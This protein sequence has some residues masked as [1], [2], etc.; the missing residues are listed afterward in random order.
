MSLGDVLSARMRMAAGSESTPEIAQDLVTIFTMADERF[1]LG[2][3]ALLNSL[4]LTGHADLPVVVLDGGLTPNQRSAIERFAALVPPPPGARMGTA[5]AKAEVASLEPS[6]VVLVIDADCIVTGSLRE[7]V[8]RATAGQICAVRDD[9]GPGFERR[10]PEWEGLFEL[11]AAVRDVGTY[12]NCG[13]LCLSTDHWPDVLPRWA[14]LTRRL[15]PGRYVRGSTANPIR[16]ADQDV[17]NAILMSEVPERALHVLPVGTMAYSQWRHARAS[18]VGSLCVS[19]GVVPSTVVHFSLAP[20]P[21]AP[22]GWKRVGRE[23]LLPLLGRCLVGDGLLL[24]PERL[25]VPWWLRSQGKAADCLR[26]VLA[27]R[28]HTSHALRRILWGGYDR[29]PER[30]RAALKRLRGQPVAD[31]FAVARAPTTQAP[32]AYRERSDAEFP[33]TR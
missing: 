10:F 24:E 20:K 30:G 5:L 2:L 18:D 17:F 16:N 33:T 12:V 6:G 23:P 1:Y 19:V 29:F 27:A 13:F 26:M 28:N 8:R 4:H 3:V 22:G 11:H 9:S 7:V 21:W 25:S 15:P 32:D 31:P 14:E